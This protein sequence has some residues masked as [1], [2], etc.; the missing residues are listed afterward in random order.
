MTRRRP[1]GGDDADERAVLAEH[2]EARRF[3]PRQRI[4]RAG[5]SGEKAYV[6]LSGQVQIV[7]IDEDN[8]EIVVDP[9]GPGG[10][11]GLASMLAAAPHQTT[12]VA[13]DDAEAI[14]IDRTDI[15]ALLERKPL[16]GLDMLTMVGR[17]FRAAQELVRSRAAR[18]PNE[19]IDE[20]LTLGERV[21]DHSAA[22]G[23]S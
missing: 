23:P 15:V 2:V 21:A 17:Q 1:P 16:A 10:I 12:A 4:Y 18:N 13:L 7:M 9:P 14:E 20:Q 6:V 5:D 8:Q 3:S 19:V 22:R 11:C